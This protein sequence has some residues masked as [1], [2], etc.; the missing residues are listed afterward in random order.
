LIGGAEITPAN[1]RFFAAPLP[2]VLHIV[3]V[4]L[5]ALL[6]A[7]QFVPSLRRRRG[8][9]RA[10]GLILVPSGL[11]VA[12]SGLW[13]TLAYRMPPYDGALVYALRLLFGSAMLLSLVLGVAALLQRDFAEHGNWMLRSYAIGMGAGTQ[14]LTGMITAA[15]ADPPTELSRAIVLGA[16][17]VINLAMAEWVIRRRAPRAHTPLVVDPRVR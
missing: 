6:G 16:G 14:V 3:S 10:A 9:H 13:M 11:I 2:V 15:F 7:F 5:Y 12:L 17:W 4:T 8:W 1:E